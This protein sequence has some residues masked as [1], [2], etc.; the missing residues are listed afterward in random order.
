MKPYRQSPCETCDRLDTVN[1]EKCTYPNWSRYKDR[2]NSG[3]LIVFLFA[4][5][6]GAMV[7]TTIVVIIW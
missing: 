4:A 7:V 2:D 1:C 6:I 3:Q 5:L